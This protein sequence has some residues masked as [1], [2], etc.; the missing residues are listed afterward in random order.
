MRDICGVKEDKVLIDYLKKAD[1]NAMR[2]L[3]LF[4]DNNSRKAIC[5]VCNHNKHGEEMERMAKKTSENTLVKKHNLID[6]TYLSD[7]DDVDNIPPLPIIR[8][9][10]F[11][12]D[13]FN[14]DDNKEKSFKFQDISIMNNKKHNNNNN[15]HMEL[16]V[17]SMSTAVSQ[18]HYGANGNKANYNT[19][20]NKVNQRKCIQCGITGDSY[21]LRCPL[22]IDVCVDCFLKCNAN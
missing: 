21:L 19:H 7:N 9:P 1:G 15:N 4:Y 14:D 8:I 16:T 22:Q 6:L 3:N 12:C 18:Q 13:T 5:N 10:K 11:E 2:A 20:M 17:Q